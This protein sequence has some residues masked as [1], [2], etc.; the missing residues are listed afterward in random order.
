[1]ITTVCRDCFGEFG[2]APVYCPTCGSDRFV[3]HS[4][5]GKLSLAHID[6]DGFY[7]AVEKRDNPLLANK[8]VLIG[9]ARRGVV[10]TACY[11]ARS[12]GPRSAMP[13]Y[14]ALQLCP[15][16]VVVR[17]NMVKYRQVSRRMRKIFRDA[18][19]LV[20]PVFLDEAYLDLSGTTRLFRRTAAAT[21]ANIA[22]KVE[23]KEG[24][25]VSVGLSYNKLLA[26]MASDLDKPEGFA[27]IGR[28]DAVAFLHDL[29]I[30]KIPGVGPALAKRLN[31]DGLLK[32]GHLQAV[33]EAVLKRRYGDTGRQLS[34]FSRGLDHRRIISNRPAKGVS[35]ETTFETSISDT[36]SLKKRLWPLCES[37]AG[38][39]KKQGLA[40]HT[41]T[42][43]LKSDRFELRTRSQKLEAPTQLAE[44][45]YLTSIAL[46]DKEVICQSFRLIGVGVTNLSDG[47]FAD[48]PDLLDPAVQRR[49]QLE[50]VMDEVR[51]KFGHKS[52]RKGRS[53]V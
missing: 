14:Q 50:Y 53:D 15:T 12:Y 3:T 20:E 24:I 17:P 8:P 52:I 6:C 36:N 34:L 11:V 4:E 41:V 38:R 33:T 26:K 23:M 51:G 46:L 21:L 13:M 42:L 2:A 27:V 30:H 35:S 49:A 39:L 44:N 31:A 22:R 48:P 16:A 5:L 28:G 29:A 37:V 47:T 9:N 43:K 7:A 1:M 10:M 25:T 18:T 32:I 19:P 45:L 40:G